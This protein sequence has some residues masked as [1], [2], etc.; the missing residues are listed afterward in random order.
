M[1][2][3]IQGMI[4]DQKK[5]QENQNLYKTSTHLHWNLAKSSW[6]CDRYSKKWAIKTSSG[7]QNRTLARTS[8]VEG[9]R[10]GGLLWSGSEYSPD[11]S[12]LFIWIMCR[13]TPKWAE[14]GTVGGK[15][16]VF[17]F[18]LHW[19]EGGVKGTTDRKVREKYRYEMKKADRGV[20]DSLKTFWHF[21]PRAVSRQ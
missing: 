17:N 16:T 3:L 20:S 2:E 14:K 19:E 4:L 5:K 6:M 1:E 8:N 9:L 10:V 12:E 18:Q 21:K 13:F 15:M 11:T 7:K